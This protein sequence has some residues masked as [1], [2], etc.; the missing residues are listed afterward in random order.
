MTTEINAGRVAM[1]PKGEW[2]ASTAYVRLDVVQHGGS[3]W[4]CIKDGTGQEPASGST[5]WQ[6]LAAGIPA[7]NYYTKTQVDT[8]LQDKQDALV[9][10]QNIKTVNNESLLGS[11]NVTVK[12]SDLTFT[13]TQSGTTYTADKTFAEIQA[14]IRSGAT[15][16]GAFDYGG[17]MVLLSLVGQSV[18]SIIFAALNG[19]QVIAF[20][21]SASAVTLVDKNLIDSDELE[22]V[23]G[24][25]VAANW[26]TTAMLGSMYAVT[27][28]DLDAL[29]IA[30]NANRYIQLTFNGGEWGGVT[31]FCGGYYIDGS[32]KVFIFTAWQSANLLF[33][34]LYPSGVV[35]VTALNV[36]AKQDALV[37]GQNIKSINGQSVLGTGNL[38][39]GEL[40]VVTMT[41][42]NSV[43]TA[44]KSVSEIY[45]ASYTNGKPVIAVMRDISNPV[46]ILTDCNPDGDSYVFSSIESNTVTTLRWQRTDDY[47]YE[48]ETIVLQPHLVSG[49]NIKTVNSASLLGSGNLTITT[50]VVDDLTTGG[51]S[52]AL[53]A[54][55]GKVIGSAILIRHI[56]LL[57]PTDTEIKEGYYLRGDAATAS[58]VATAMYDV[59]GF[60]PVEY[61]KTYKIVTNVDLS[62]S[63]RTN[64][65]KFSC[66]FDANKN[67]IGGSTQENIS[68]V[69]IDNALCKY[70]KITFFNRG[71]AAEE[72]ARTFA[73]CCF[74]EQSATN[75]FVQ[76]GYTA[77]ANHPDNIDTNE[78]FATKGYVGNMLSS[79]NNL[80]GKKWVA[81]GDSYTT[82]DFTPLAKSEYKFQDEPYMGKNKVYPYFIGRRRRMVIVNEAKSGSTMTYIDG[83]LNEFSTANGRYTNIPADADYITLYFGINDENHSAPIGTINDNVNTTFYGA[84]NIVLSYLINNYPN[85]KIGII[86]T[87]NTL[88]SS[89]TDAEKAIAKKYGIGILNFADNEE[90]PYIYRQ[91][92]RTSIPNNIRSIYDNR[93]RV[94]ATNSHPNVAMHERESYIIEQWLLSL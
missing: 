67:Y 53:S 2:S 82:G 22:T 35:S 58:Y 42:H 77:V 40:F 90:M 84:W 12:P 57:N 27:G 8:A 63:E 75:V 31:C 49:T 6:L 54:E 46:F 34:E 55:Q 76:Y 1:V 26:T 62:S 15:V 33:V 86:I 91:F 45:A 52:A 88:N 94:G 79:I 65:I 87:N 17:Y 20:L 93:F 38:E 68:T 69:T 7:T 60:L 85:A 89:Y 43:Y 73:N 30:Y 50:E 66:F 47:T 74:C 81:C 3:A 32:D 29:V 11:G 61:G 71:A 92:L 28:Y 36:A 9:S 37:S 78:D 59:S 16:M 24:V 4:V 14:A 19:S 83:T 18:D 13:I 51:S 41:Q 64:L 10:G 23:T 39:L 25:R 72:R 44:D 48:L 56:N 5:Y 70:V 21:I 80:Y